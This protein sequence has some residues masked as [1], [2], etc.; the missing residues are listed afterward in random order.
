MKKFNDSDDS[1][2]SD[3]RLKLNQF[4]PKVNGGLAYSNL[5]N[6]LHKFSGPFKFLESA[7]LSV[8]CVYYAFLL[9]SN[10]RLLFF[11]HRNGFLIIITLSSQ[12]ASS[13]FLK[14]SPP[15]NDLKSSLSSSSLLFCFFFLSS[16]FRC[17]VTI[18]GN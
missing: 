10:D 16:L 18:S 3:T 2:A 1:S 14:T 8:S 12:T 5:F 17:Y 7:A 11:Y 4:Y 15:T 13:S 9:G 6:L